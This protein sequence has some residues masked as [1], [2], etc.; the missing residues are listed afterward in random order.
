MISMAI[1]Y[2]GLHIF[3]CLDKAFVSACEGGMEDFRNAK[4]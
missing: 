2:I 4:F 1:I 3:K